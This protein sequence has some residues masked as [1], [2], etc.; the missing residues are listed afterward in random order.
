MRELPVVIGFPL[1]K[2]KIELTSLGVGTLPVAFYMLPTIICKGKG[3]MYNSKIMMLHIPFQVSMGTV[4]LLTD[5]QL[6]E[7]GIT[8]IGDRANF[9][10][11]CQEIEK[12][13]KICVL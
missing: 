7:L 10:K 1:T 11:K 9:R 13:I 5:A 4:R 2:L 6:N 3:M 8:R 12:G